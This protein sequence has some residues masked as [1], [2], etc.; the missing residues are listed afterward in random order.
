MQRILPNS[1][2]THRVLAGLLLFLLAALGFASGLLTTNPLIITEKFQTFV[3]IFLGIFIE[4]V[5]FLLAG[6]IVSGIIEVFVDRETLYRF[7][8]RK[9]L[10]AALSGAAMGIA[11]PV[12][13]CG[14]VPVTRR[15]YQKGLPMSMGIA[16]LLA[17]PVINPV[18][19]ASTYAAYGWGPMLWGR[20]ALS[21]LFAA[22]VGFVFH[23]AKPSE[24]LL[25][26][27]LTK[28]TK[29]VSPQ[30][31]PVTAV[32]G[33]GQAISAVGVLPISESGPSAHP[34]SETVSHRSA[35]AHSQDRMWQV[36]NL[37]G[38]DFL[39]MGRYLIAGS[40]LAAGM[41]TLVPQSVLLAIGSGPVIS[42]IAMLVL[43]YVL[44]VCSTVDAFLSLAFVNSFSSASI[45]GFLVF[46][47]MVDIKSSL[48]FLG[49]F[50]R[51]V[52]LYLILLPL[53]LTMT[54][55]IYLNLNVGW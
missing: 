1:L 34:E 28:S 15:L 55:A 31:Q 17:A 46:G 25:P 12:C 45:L 13:E 18:V 24:V 21:F 16:F 8:P 39:D 27:L 40:M 53:L 19:V 54:V 6:S 44:S 52:V 36:M 2:T 43:A 42:V 32:A 26:H 10:L 3:T 30:P 5:P 22:I 23:L 29:P 41:Q 11:F 33:A 38:E 47:P 20:L 51:R 50:R 48:L 9:P 49:V 4:A 14:V 7:V 37:A 35:P